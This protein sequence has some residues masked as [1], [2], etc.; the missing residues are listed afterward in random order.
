MEVRPKEFN[1]KLRTWEQLDRGCDAI[2]NT[3]VKYIPDKLYLDFNKIK[4]PNGYRLLCSYRES[5]LFNIIVRY[6]FRLPALRQETIERYIYQRLCEIAKDHTFSD[7]EITFI[8]KQLTD[9]EYFDMARQQY[10]YMPAEVQ[11]AMKE[12]Y[13]I[14]HAR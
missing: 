2:Y 6:G 10:E 5:L 3:T 13:M 14:R 9:I 4:L 1:P 8:I 11:N 12:I 7:K